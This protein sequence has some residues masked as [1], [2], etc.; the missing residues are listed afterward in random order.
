MLGERI[1]TK[2]K[3]LSWKLAHS[4]VEDFIRSQRLTA[5]IEVNIYLWEDNFK[6]GPRV[7]EVSFFRPNGTGGGAGS[8]YMQVDLPYGAAAC[9]CAERLIIAYH[10]GWNKEDLQDEEWRMAKAIKQ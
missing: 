3:L 8:S 5:D 7:A 10:E 6:L 4:K 1:M 9:L 2:T